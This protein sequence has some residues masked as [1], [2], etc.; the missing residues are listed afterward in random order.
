MNKYSKNVKLNKALTEIESDLLN[1]GINEVK[2][3]YDTFK[4]E[5][6]FNIVQYANLL[7]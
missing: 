4:N 3:Y 5:V 7:I 2:R 6:H 1:L